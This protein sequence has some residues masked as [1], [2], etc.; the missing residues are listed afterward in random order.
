MAQSFHRECIEDLKSW[1]ALARGEAKPLLLRGARQ[2]GK[3]TL[4]RLFA[5]SQKLHLVELNLEKEARFRKIFE[6]DN[7]SDLIR[8]LEIQL[9]V[10][11]A[12]KKLLLFVD[13]IQRVPKAIESLRYFYEDYPGVKVVAA[14]SLLDFALTQEKLSMPVGRVQ[15]YYVSP[16][17]FLEFLDATGLARVSGFLK[18]YELGMSIPST[19]HDTCLKSLREYFLVGGMPEAVRSWVKYHDFER[20]RALQHSILDTYRDDF[21]KYASGRELVRIQRIFDQIPAQV[22]KKVKYSALDPLTHARDLRH[23]LDSLA[24]ARVLRKVHY[25]SCVSLPLHAGSEELVYK[26]YALDVG[27]MNVVLGVDLPQLE[28]ARG[29]GLLDLGAM[30]E[31]VVFQNLLA[32]SRAQDLPLVYWLRE[33]RQANAKLDFVMA[34]GAEIIP[35]EVK[36]GK[37][38][39]LKSLHQFIAAKKCR[40][41]LRFDLNQPASVHVKHDVVTPNGVQAV[42]FEL[43][44]LPLYL[45]SE[46]R[47]IALSSKGGRAS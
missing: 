30:A 6:E 3:S 11:L 38:G 31:Q 10:N 36:S 22:G 19:V 47:R 21:T 2:V 37:S 14:G 33:A 4:V 5:E 8:A 13:E 45:S 34:L 9:G 46:A 20:V 26:L 40:R 24:K 7:F 18:K 16:L 41:A 42:E 28:R 27:L 43:L 32:S 44:S 25:S 12:D 23:A 17:T 15:Y 39:S 29:E 35:I 1:F